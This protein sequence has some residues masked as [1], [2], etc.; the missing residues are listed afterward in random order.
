MDY[1]IIRIL[2]KVI[3]HL[4]KETPEYRLKAFFKEMPI[5]TKFLLILI[6]LISLSRWVVQF[7]A[8]W[9]IYLIFDSRPLH[10]VIAGK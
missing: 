10:E 7:N 9:I 6:C 1:Q 3:K 4:K 2:M 5:I 8:L